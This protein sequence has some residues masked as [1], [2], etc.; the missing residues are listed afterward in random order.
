MLAV[1]AERIAVKGSAA[2][3]VRTDLCRKAATDW[4]KHEKFVIRRFSAHE[5]A[6][7]GPGYRADRRA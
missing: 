7:N 5:F 3:A 2:A 4:I 1:H 6:P